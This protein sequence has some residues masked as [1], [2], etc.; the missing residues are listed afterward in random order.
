MRWF[1]VRQEGDIREHISLR[2][3][4][5]MGPNAVPIFGAEHDGK[6]VVFDRILLRR[7]LSPYR[8]GRVY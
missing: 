7:G 8:K 5:E 1:I 3:L 2:A 6:Y 4:K